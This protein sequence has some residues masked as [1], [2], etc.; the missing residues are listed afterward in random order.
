MRN[1][2]IIVIAF[3]LCLSAC[4]GGE[5]QSKLVG[6]WE[7]LPEPA[8]GSN[9]WAYE[10]FEDGTGFFV[11]GDQ[12]SEFNYKQ[13]GSELQITIID[14]NVARQPYELKTKFESESNLTLWR[15]NDKGGLFWEEAWLRKPMFDLPIELKKQLVEEIPYEFTILDAMISGDD[16]EEWTLTI[17]TQRGHNIINEYQIRKASSLAEWSVVKILNTEERATATV[18]AVREITATAEWSEA[19][20]AADF[21][22]TLIAMEPTA[23]PRLSNQDLSSMLARAS[24]LCSNSSNS[25]GKPTNPIRVP[26]PGVVITDIDR[27]PDMEFSWE[28]DFLQQ[29]STPDEV[30]TLV[31]ILTDRAKIWDYSNGSVGYTIIRKVNILS[32][33]DGTLLLQN[34]FSGSSPQQIITSSTPLEPNSSIYGSD[35]KDAI[36]DWVVSVIE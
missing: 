29:A 3:F 11:E 36:M 18:K 4:S 25:S 7:R 2:F 24:T 10:F 32:W 21:Q 9:T 16:S 31:C 26:F 28:S 20:R 8:G 12:A 30:Q 33:P 17:E 6:R 14:S 15:V 27:G 23:I 22:Q 34:E 1:K 35:P 19:T 13:S 5:E